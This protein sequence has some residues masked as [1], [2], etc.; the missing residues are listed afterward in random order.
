MQANPKLDHRL[1][2]LASCLREV[3]VRGHKILRPYTEE[4]L[5]ETKQ[6]ILSDLLAIVGEDEPEEYYTKRMGRMVAHPHKE[7]WAKNKLRAQL[8]Q[9]IQAYV[10]VES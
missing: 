8:R 10:G 2:N 6:T 4:Q 5:N 7:N 3:E 1:S 9:A